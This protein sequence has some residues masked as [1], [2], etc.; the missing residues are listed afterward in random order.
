MR[1]DECSGYHPTLLSRFTRYDELPRDIPLLLTKNEMVY[2][3]NAA[4][5]E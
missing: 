4:Q 5:L 2:R 3:F 1:R